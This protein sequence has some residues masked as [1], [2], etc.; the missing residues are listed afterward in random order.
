MSNEPGASSHGHRD[1]CDANRRSRH[2]CGQT[3]IK[4]LHATLGEHDIRGIQ[5]IVNDAL[6]MPLVEGASD[7]NRALEG[8]VERQGAV[9]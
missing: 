4:Q 5:G 2:E 9:L 3:E 1:S 7:L 6:T 8:L